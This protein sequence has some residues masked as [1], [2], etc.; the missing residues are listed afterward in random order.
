MFSTQHQ[1]TFT[2]ADAQRRAE[3]EAWHRRNPDVDT[4][5]CVRAFL[6]VVAARKVKQ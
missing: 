4:T 2:A 3:R 5:Q 6:A 1:R